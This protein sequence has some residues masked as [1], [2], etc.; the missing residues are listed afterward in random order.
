[1]VLGPRIRGP[2]APRRAPA[3]RRPLGGGG[4]SAA[5]VPRRRPLGGGPSAAAPRRW[6]LGG[7]PR[8]GGGPSAAAAPRRW[9][10]GG[11]PLVRRFFP[12]LFRKSLFCFPE[13]LEN[14]FLDSQDQNKILMF[15]TFLHVDRTSTI[16]HHFLA[17]SPQKPLKS[18]PQYQNLAGDLLITH[19]DHWGP[20]SAQIYLQ[21]RWFCHRS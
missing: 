3:R 4:P 8:G 11:G 7:R 18:S 15:N 6:P 9:H 10:L 21:K 1:M 2:R 20:V 19:S 14:R 17:P 16:N 5:A 12:I 13:I